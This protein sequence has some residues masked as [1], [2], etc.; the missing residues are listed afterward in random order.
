LKRFA[1]SPLS[2]DNPMTQISY[3]V[4]SLEFRTESWLGYFQHS[5]F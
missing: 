3:T 4:S 2:P 5:S 1:R